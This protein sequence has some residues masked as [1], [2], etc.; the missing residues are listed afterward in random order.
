MLDLMT[1]TGWRLSV[2]VGDLVRHKRLV[3]HRGII[4]AVDQPRRH[5][6]LLDEESHIFWE[7]MSEYEVISE[8]R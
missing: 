2:K 1:S 7:K 5:V 8:S 6:K 3:L 4:V